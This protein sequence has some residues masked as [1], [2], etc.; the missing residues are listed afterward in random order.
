M[1]R[2]Y[3]DA[4]TWIAYFGQEENVSKGKGK[5]SENRFQ[6]CSQV[7]ARAKSCQIVIV[8]SSISLSEVQKIRHDSK[9]PKGFMLEY[10]KRDH[11]LLIPENNI[12]R[13]SAET[14]R[15]GSYGKIGK[16]DSIHLATA[17]RTDIFEFHTFDDGLLRLDGMI[18][19][20]KGNKLKICKPPETGLGSLDLP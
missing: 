8:T 15:D 5:G 9:Y 7:M 4:C 11:V 10:T 14:L 20:S 17:L 13:N 16:E 2:V 18:P 19:D 6:M 1:N 3:W 12:V